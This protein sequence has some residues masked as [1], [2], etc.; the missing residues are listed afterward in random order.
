MESAAAMMKKKAASAVAAGARVVE[1]AM[2]DIT[3]PKDPLNAFDNVSSL[4]VKQ[5]VDKAEAA[6]QLAAS[7]V[8]AGMM[9]S[10]GEKEN[11]YNVYSN[12]GG[13]IFQAKEE[14]EYCGLDGRAL[15]AP[16]HA[17]KLHLFKA[18]MMN[19]AM[20]AVTGATK[21]VMLVDRPCYCGG[22]CACCDI[23][24]HKANLYAAPPGG[25]A[26]MVDE[27]MLVASVRQPFMGGG[28]SPTLDVMDRDGTTKLATVTGPACCIGGNC[29]D[30]TFDVTDASG[31]NIGQ[32]LKKKPTDFNDALA[33]GLSDA[34]NFTLSVK[35]DLDKKVKAALMTSLLMLD[36]S[37]FEGEGDVSVNILE[38]SCSYKCCDMHCCGAVCPCSCTCSRS[39]EH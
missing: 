1:S 36:Y 26:A 19:K 7:A 8:G 12:S 3:L 30:N 16:N 10:L 13:L 15:C 33:Q 23:C 29:F 14:S 39:E 25:G 11:V 21:E 2:V 24:Q 38:G 9:G 32:I 22:C 17:V 35:P 20:S 34:D 18:D 6:A 28:L 37:F 27:T 5:K 31:N 4:V